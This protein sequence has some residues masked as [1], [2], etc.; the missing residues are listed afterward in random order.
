[1]MLMLLLMSMPVPEFLMPKGNVLLGQVSLGPNS[2]HANKII[3]DKWKKAKARLGQQS[4]GQRL[5]S[6]PPLPPLPLSQISLFLENHSRSIVENDR[7][8][9]PRPAFPIPYLSLSPFASSGAVSTILISCRVP[10][11][12]G[13]APRCDQPGSIPISH[14]G[15][16]TS[17]IPLIASALF[18]IFL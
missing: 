3:Q 10:G 17:P 6:D 13:T 5:L 9:T 18:A 12:L 4:S 15:T 14:A 8:Q 11:N 7:V 16:R 2:T 1:M